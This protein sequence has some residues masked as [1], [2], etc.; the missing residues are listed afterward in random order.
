MQAWLHILL[1]L[2]LLLGEEGKS[3]EGNLLLPDYQSIHQALS[4]QSVSFSND[5]FV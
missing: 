3:D 2:E 4:D 5:L 1:E